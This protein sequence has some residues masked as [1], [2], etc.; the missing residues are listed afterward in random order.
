MN[1]LL[2]S[3]IF[4]PDVCSN[5]YVFADLADELHRRGHTVTVITTTPHYGGS[6]EGLRNGKASWYRI[7][8]YHGMK[9]YHICVAPQKGDVQ[10]RLQTY[11]LFH[12]YATKLLK[13]EPIS[14]DVVL[15]QTPPPL[16]GAPICKKLAKKLHAKSVLI[17]QDLWFDDLF[18]AGKIG[19]TAFRA[20][21][22]IEKNVYEQMD[23]VVTLSDD[24]AQLIKNK[25]VAANK[26]SV[27]ANPVNTEIYHP[28]KETDEMRQSFGVAPS[29]F[30]ISYVGNI[31][32]AQD[33]TPLIDYAKQ[34]TD[35]GTVILIAGNG[36]HEQQ[37]RAMA[38][39]LSNVRFLGYVSREVSVEMNAISD[40]C[41]VMLAEHVT[42]TC[43]PS[44]L[45][46][47]MAM[48]KPIL[49][50]CREDSSLRDYV[51]KMQ[52]GLSAPVTASQVV[53]ASIDELRSDHEK[54][55]A[56]GQN[57][58]SVAMRDFALVAVGGEYEALLKNLLY[59]EVGEVRE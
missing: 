36:V 50:V 8:D 37:Y 45:C 5:A 57:A 38:E 33:L 2:Y 18:H 43:F 21:A 27:I 31:G 39:G 23:A 9:T 10:Q 49:L 41:T 25:G 7:G 53:A 46:T 44:K 47:L 22:C 11:W 40:V 42:N 19:R 12:R 48:G 4:P 15:T 16:T 34:H 55:V 17:L 54:R 35:D 6:A 1:V 24:M 52:I 13:T 56:Y 51:A 29:D 3:L 32:T 28:S 20:A 14:A 58:Y 30:V 59:S 26:I